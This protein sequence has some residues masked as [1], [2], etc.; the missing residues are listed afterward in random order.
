VKKQEALNHEE[1]LKLPIREQLEAR[2]KDRAFQRDSRKAT[3]DQAT[4]TG[5]G[6]KSP[7]GGK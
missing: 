3:D 1:L 6:R 7:G 4:V 5:S 2:R